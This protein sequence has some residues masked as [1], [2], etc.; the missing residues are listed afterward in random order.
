[1]ENPI[2]TNNPPAAEIKTGK[3]DA[4]TIINYIA[5]Y[6]SIIGVVFLAAIAGL[7]VVDVLLRV[8]LNHP[9]L[10]STE[11]TEYMM[12]LLVLGSGLCALRGRQIKMDLL[13]ERFPPRTQAYID[14]ITNFITLGV[15]GTMAW[16]TF[17]EALALKGLKLVSNILKI[18]TY[19]FYMILSLGLVILCLALVVLTTNSIIKAIKK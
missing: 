11:V 2:I 5:R 17:S 15:F 10:G 9:I 7:T 3:I 18:P 16:F 1:M 4:V 12:I 14:S 13:V 6:A 19:P 8:T